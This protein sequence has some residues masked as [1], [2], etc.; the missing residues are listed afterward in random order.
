MKPVFSLSAREYGP[1]KLWMRTLFTQ[2]VCQG[3]GIS[4]YLLYNCFAT[5]S[6]FKILNKNCIS[7]TLI[8]RVFYLVIL[9]CFMNFWFTSCFLARKLEQD[10][11]NIFRKVTLQAPNFGTRSLTH[12]FS[13]FNFK[14]PLKHWKTVNFSDVA[15]WYRD[16]ELRRN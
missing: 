1:E 13:K 11:S 10:V 6:L 3:S 8:H 15:R 4:N 9:L 12:F 5:V 7:F 16:V 14:I 2:C